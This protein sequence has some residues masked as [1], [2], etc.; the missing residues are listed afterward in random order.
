[1]SRSPG[2]KPFVLASILIICSLLVGGTPPAA[3]SGRAPAQSAPPSTGAG[4]EIPPEASADWWSRVQREISSS[5]YHLNQQISPRSLGV[6]E[7]WQASNRAH[8]FRTY[9]TDRGIRIVPRIGGKPSWEW[10]LSLI[11]YGRGDT[12]SSV[13]AATPSANKNRIDLERGDVTEWYINE[14]GGLKQ[15]FTL[16]APP[17]AISN[18]VQRRNAA[19]GS[20][21][22]PPLPSDG[23]RPDF[24][25]YLLLELGGD[26][27]PFI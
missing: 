23:T 14:P 18:G 21:A 7:A 5:E 12:I 11:G 8:G 6:Q 20:Q 22:V 17:E 3:A 15:G 9:F 13:S 10:S 1:M 2:N 25:A 26:L 16:A 24:M 27:S 19:M 4:I